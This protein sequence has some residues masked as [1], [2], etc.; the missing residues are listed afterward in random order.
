MDNQAYWKVSELE[1]EGQTKEALTLLV[2]LADNK[3]PLALLELSIRYLSTEGY[4]NPVEKIESDE[5]KSNSLALEAHNQL[6]KLSNEGDGEAMR[7][8][9]TTYL[10]HWHPFIPEKDINKAEQWL[11]KSYETGHY[12]AA[13]DLAILCISKDINE[14][15]YWYKE[16]DKHNCRVIYD[17]KLEG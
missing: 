10:N 3:H 7:V 8:L 14:A 4:I 6:I 2:K 12:F 11:L 15:K 9:A 16:A 13:N 1:K 5:D 17:P